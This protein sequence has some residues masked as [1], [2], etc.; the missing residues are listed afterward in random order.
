[1]PDRGM[2]SYKLTLY[3]GGMAIRTWNTKGQVE[4]HGHSEG[5]YFVD[6]A[7]GKMVRVSGTV[8]IE[9]LP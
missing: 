8:A 7:T 9:Q 1:M 5:Y 4:K 3:S 6:I 2:I